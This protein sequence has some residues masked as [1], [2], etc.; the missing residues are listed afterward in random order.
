MRKEPTLNDIELPEIDLSNAGIV[1]GVSMV[2][3][4]THIQIT[5]HAD[6]EYVEHICFPV[7]WLE[8]IIPGLRAILANEKLSE[9]IVP[10]GVC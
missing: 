1:N 3:N 7:I 9:Q 5:T 10:K 8:N 4:E 6:G 2:N